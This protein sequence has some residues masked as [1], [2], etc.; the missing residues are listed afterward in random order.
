MQRETLRHAAHYHESTL[1]L[2]VRRRRRAIGDRRH[3]CRYC[4]TTL[5]VVAHLTGKPMEI[6]VMYVYGRAISSCP[7][8]RNDFIVLGLVNLTRYCFNGV[9]RFLSLLR[10]DWQDDK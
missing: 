1:F 10:L 6:N 9:H 5:S 3:G 7:S 8:I 2:L 4:S